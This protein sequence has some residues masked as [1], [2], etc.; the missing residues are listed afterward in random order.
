[1]RLLSFR[2]LTSDAQKAKPI[3][4]QI[5]DLVKQVLPL[6]FAD[7][8]MQYRNDVL[9][10]I[11]L[12]IKRIRATS[13]NARK[14]LGNAQSRV[15]N[16]E[17]VLQSILHNARKF[18]EWLVAYCRDCLT[19]GRTFYTTSMALDLLYILSTEEFFT[20]VDLGRPPSTTWG[21]HLKLFSKALVRLLID[22]L[23]DPYEGVARVALSLLSMMKDKKLIPLPELHSKGLELCNSVRTDRSQGG[24][25]ALI[26]C[27]KFQKE[28][29][30]KITWNNI[31]QSV[32]RDIEVGTLESLALK[33]PLQGRLV[34]LRYSPSF[35][36]NADLRCMDYEY[37]RG[38]F[39]LVEDICKLLWE[40]AGPILTR[41]SPEGNVHVFGQPALFTHLTHENFIDH[42]HKNGP[43]EHDDETQE[44]LSSSWRSLKEATALLAHAIGCPSTTIDDFTNVG[45]MLM[46]WLCKIRHRGAFSAIMP[47]FEQIISLC[48][49]DQRRRFHTLPKEW[50]K[51]SR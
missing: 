31:A 11:H 30:R 35:L 37:D 51:V 45:K 28:S 33:T 10:T 48:C 26:L 40:R 29:E 49:V 50:L 43:L 13:Y 47:S 3:S 38:A 4:T 12:F 7:D 20:D 17:N 18:T 19:P 6:T 46:E 44:I 22:R 16:H 32:N 9:H 42:L 27:A 24:A 36:E 1:M 25:R 23:A 21:L 14:E 34:A 8:D 15:A 39:L 2:F 5:Y 41:D